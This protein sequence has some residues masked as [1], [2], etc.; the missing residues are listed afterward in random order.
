MPTF[1]RNTGTS[2]SACNRTT[3]CVILKEDYDCYLVE[4]YD[5]FS[6]SLSACWILKE[7]ITFEELDNEL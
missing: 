1:V 2:N 4:F 7:D 5:T 6:E 3:A